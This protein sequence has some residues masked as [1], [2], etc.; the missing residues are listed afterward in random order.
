MN[1]FMKVAVFYP[2]NNILE[3]KSGSSRR[4]GEML[5]VLK[6]EFSE[7]QCIS[8]CEMPD[9]RVGNIHYT[10][11]PWPSDASSL[12]SRLLSLFMK[13]IDVVT[14]GRSRG[15]E[16]WLWLHCKFAIDP[17]FAKHA[18]KIA[19]MADVI[20]VEFTFLALPIIRAC[21][22]KNKKVIITLHD[23]LSDHVTKSKLLKYLTAKIERAA[24]KKANCIVCTSLADKEKLNK[25][26]ISAEVIEHG[27]DIQRYNNET[28]NS[29][30]STFN[31]FDKFN[32]PRRNICLFVGA[33]HLPN[34]EAVDI[35][36]ELAKSM[37]SPE[38]DN[39][40]FVI[41]GD[42]CKL[43]RSDNFFALGKIE[44]E[45]LHALYVAAD[46]VLIPLDKGGGSSLKTIEAMA[47][48]KTILGTTVA[49]RGYPVE[50][51]V[52]CVISDRYSEYA[53]IIR[54]LLSDQ[55]RRRKIGQKARKFAELYDSHR[56][57]K[58]YIDLISA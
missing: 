29:L 21:R 26:G 58:K 31:V 41:V 14:R 34:F 45:E 25:L 18:E 20:I 39:M 15:E 11:F 2:W 35:I 23:I 49:F 48:G 44:E 5:D 55:D 37:Q 16:N 17:V 1:A 24:M 42:C 13:V 9:N 8:S 30:Q 33:W 46:L 27:I 52:N 38:K 19:D 40:I 12:T 50:S 7:I 54:D 51:N 43:E 36:R 57:Y 6:D 47:Y 53:D 22:Q 32:L 4:T 3:R 28:Q 56:L 10:G